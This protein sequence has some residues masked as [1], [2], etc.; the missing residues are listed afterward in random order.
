AG[1]GG[2][3]ISLGGA[4]NLFV[5]NGPTAT[6]SGSAVGSG[7]DTFRFDGDGANTFDM[8]QI[9]AGWT[10]LDKQGSSNWTLTGTASYSG[11][12]TVNA[13]TL[14]VNGDLRTASGVTVSAG[15]T[16]GG[17]GFV[18]NTVINS[19]GT[20]SPGNSIGLMTVNGTL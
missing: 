19:G 15:G 9:G 14:L 3:A 2:T 5:M 13:G 20:L 1:T 17:N 18:P 12:V 6:M 10:L 7:T 8:S 4:N 16:L 11:P